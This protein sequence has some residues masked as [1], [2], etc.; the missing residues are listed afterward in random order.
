MY[1][2]YRLQS[3]KFPEQNYTGITTDISSRLQSHNNGQ[4]AHTSQYKPWKIMNYFAFTDERKA[5]DF[6]VYLKPGSGR[7]FANKHF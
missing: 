7:A 4:V 5:K 2:V 6:E 3:V 1:Y